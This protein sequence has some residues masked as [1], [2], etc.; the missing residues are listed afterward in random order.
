MN[1]D[2]I[3]I[4]MFTKDT[5]YEIEVEKLRNS[6][7]HFNI[8]YDIV[9]INGVGN[10]VKN[11]QLKTLIIKDAINKYNIPIVWIDADA[12]LLKYPDFFHNV[13]GE[14]SYYKFEKYNDILTGTLYFDNTDNCKKVIDDWI[15]INNSNDIPDAKNFFYVINKIQRSGNIQLKYIPLPVEYISISGNDLVNS[16]D[17]IIIHNSKSKSFKN[18]ITIK[19]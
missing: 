10:W 15:T 16:D 7:N 18:F 6:L 2:F 11:T 19:K 9:G 17:P 14:I 5:P 8:R 4:S 1:K 3:I 12:E 13:D